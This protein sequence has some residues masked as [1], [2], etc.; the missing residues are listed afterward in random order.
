MY[1]NTEDTLTISV[2]ADGCSNYA[3]EVEAGRRLFIK[4]GSSFSFGVVPIEDMQLLETLDSP[5]MAEALKHVMDR[6]REQE[7]QMLTT[8][9]PVEGKTVIGTTKSNPLRLDLNNH[10]LIAGTSGQDRSTL[11]SV[12]IAGALASDHETEL[13]VVSANPTVYLSH[14]PTA[15]LP[16]NVRVNMEDPERIQTFREQLAQELAFRQN[17]LTQHEALTVD[18]YRRMHP[19]AP[20]ICDIVMF[21]DQADILLKDDPELAELLTRIIERGSMF[22]IYIWA[23]GAPSIVNSPVTELFTRRIALQIEDR[24]Q[25]HKLLRSDAPAP[26]SLQPFCGLL[27]EPKQRALTQF[28][29]VKSD[30]APEPLRTRG[31]SWVAKPAHAVLGEVRSMSVPSGSANLRSIPFG[32]TATPVRSQWS[33]YL[34]DLSGNVF[35]GETSQLVTQDLAGVTLLSSLALS[36]RPDQV[37]IFYIGEGWESPLLQ[38]VPHVIHACHDDD[39]DAAR[40]FNEIRA[41]S[42]AREILLKKHGVQTLDEYRESVKEAEGE[43]IPDIYLFLVGPGFRNEMDSILTTGPARGLHLVYFDAGY[44]SLGDDQSR[45]DTIITEPKLNPHRGFVSISGSDVDIRIAEPYLSVSERVQP[46]SDILEQAFTHA[47]GLRAPKLP[48][49]EP[50]KNWATL[51]ATADP[52]NIDLSQRWSEISQWNDKRRLRVPVGFKA[53]GEVFELDLKDVTEGGIGPHGMVIGRIGSGRTGFLRNLVLNLMVTHSPELVNF[54]IVGYKGDSSF[55]EL[56][57]TGHLAAHV[58]NLEE[59]D[60][61]VDRVRDSLLGELDRRGQIFRDAQTRFPNE[62]IKNHSDYMRVHAKHFRDYQLRALPALVVIVEEFDELLTRHP[63]FGK[64]LIGLNRKARS[65]GIQVVYSAQT[66]YGGKLSRD[67]EASISYKVV[68][69][70]ASASDS[71]ALLGSDAAYVLPGRPGHALVWG[72][73]LDSLESIRSGHT[74]EQ[75]SPGGSA[76]AA[77]GVEE[78]FEHAPTIWSVCIDQLRA[79]ST[80]KAYRPYVPPLSTLTLD[81]ADRKFWKPENHFVADSL[82]TIGRFDDLAQ[83]YQPDWRIDRTKSTLIIGGARKGKSIA[84]DTLLAGVALTATPQQAQAFVINYGGMHE[85]LNELAHVVAW[86]DPGQDDIVERMLL[87][88]KRI[89]RDREELFRQH[90]IRDM[91]EYRELR[92]YPDSPLHRLAQYGDVYL[93]V[94]SWNV[95]SMDG[96]VLANRAEEL[97][98]PF[99]GGDG[100]GLHLVL[101]ATGLSKIR[102]F[103][104]LTTNVIELPNDSDLSMINQNRAKGLDPQP[105]NAMVSGSEL[106][107]RIALPRIDADPNIA[108]LSK[109]IE[110]LVNSVNEESGGRAPRLPMLPTRLTRDTLKELAPASPDATAQERLRLPL[111]IDEATGEPAFAEMHREPHL[112][113]LGQA[114]SGKSETIGT[115]ISSIA[116][117]YPTK[118]DAIVLLYDTKSSSLERIPENNLYAVV[119][120]DDDFKRELQNLIDEHSTAARAVPEG[121]TLADRQARNW[122]TG[123]EIFIVVDDWEHAAPRHPGSA[124]LVHELIHWVRK[125]GYERGIHV[126]VALNTDDV[127]VRTLSDPVIKEMHASRTPVLM[128]STDKMFGSFGSVKFTDFGTPGRARYIEVAMNRDGRIQIAWSGQ[129]RQNPCPPSS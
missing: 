73:S 117:R 67:L 25:A 59:H 50:W 48:P 95:A 116:E 31:G 18:D 86:A 84:M 127:G 13:V 47:Q 58:G 105:G 7:A 92:T 102:P 108:S 114:K 96:N 120:N 100:Y 81:Q 3:K 66:A 109:G 112:L 76:P 37:Q 90:K 129:P 1:I 12:A 23:I 78:L 74:G 6:G 122:W 24:R 45:F 11:L 118:E 61:L 32:I 22:G 125:D 40:I 128:L 34:L 106:Y 113:I 21:L 56:E 77:E 103:L 8:L 83:H 97:A 33:P 87:E 54:F 71:R 107:G 126:I 89:R 36:M 91:A 110:H 82:V 65:L 39:A 79:V 93:F 115:L 53:N 85:Q 104:T 20:R 17:A 35:I 14:T 119:R 9:T 16:I 51:T 41:I 57:G 72:V 4:R 2:F 88:M 43:S 99:R 63:D 70:T 69:Q 46:Y 42:L 62:S 19:K 124:P 111:G 49:E 26:N 5:E 98:A 44:G 15:Q 38:G 121:A 10:Y 52:G 28:T 55:S 80:S 75:F 27:Q 64:F 29:L 94:D 60:S 101:S 68:F 123:P 30:I